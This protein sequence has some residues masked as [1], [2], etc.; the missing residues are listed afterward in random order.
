MERIEVAMQ[1]HRSFSSLNETYGS[2]ATFNNKYGP[3]GYPPLKSF[4]FGVGTLHKVKVG[5]PPKEKT[6]CYAAELYAA[7]CWQA[8]A[9]N[10]FPEWRV[11]LMY[12]KKVR[13]AIN[14]FFYETQLDWG[15]K[16]S[17]GKKE[18]VGKTVFEAC[19]PQV[20]FMGQMPR[21][22]TQ[23]KKVFADY[24]NE[25]YEDLFLVLNNLNAGRSGGDRH[26]CAGYFLS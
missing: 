3:M 9:T 22:L 18:Q 12:F 7:S 13:D 24:L 4:F 16:Y 21:F 10:Y 17:H 5:E 19:Y 26:T 20:E 2:F 15:E 14:F 23:E 11:S 6:F 25:V 8:K 1:L